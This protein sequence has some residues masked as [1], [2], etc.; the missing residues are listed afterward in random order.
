MKDVYQAIGDRGL[1][2][3][4]VDCLNNGRYFRDQEEFLKWW[5]QYRHEVLDGKTP[6][7]LCEEGEKGKQRLEDELMTIFVGPHG[8]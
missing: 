3:K 1:L 2:R 5:N 4:S 6:R 8:G 7:E